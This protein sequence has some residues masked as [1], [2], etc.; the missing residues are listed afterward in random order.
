M[1]ECKKCGVVMPLEGYHIDRAAKDGHR[2]EC[3]V[4]FNERTRNSKYL[5][6]YGITSAEADKLKKQPCAICGAVRNLHIDHNHTT[7][8]VRGVLCSSCNRGIGYLGDNPYR[9][10]KAK[11]YLEKEGHY[12]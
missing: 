12:G 11:E 2:N 4:C 6:R 3:K 10:Q 7:G 8:A 1:K 5:S 9:L